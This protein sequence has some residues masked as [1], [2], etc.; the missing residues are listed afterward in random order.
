MALSWFLDIFCAAENLL[1]SMHLHELLALVIEVE[2]VLSC[3]PML[4]HTSTSPSATSMSVAASFSLR[5]NW[6]VAP[7]LH[8][9]F[10]SVTGGLLL[11]SCH[12]ASACNLNTTTYCL[13][14][15]VVR[16]HR[17]RSNF[18]VRSR[19]SLTLTKGVSTDL[20]VAVVVNCACSDSSLPIPAAPSVPPGRA[21]ISNPSM[22]LP[23]L[24]CR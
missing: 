19:C 13:V 9:T 5:C 17:A 11:A 1:I 23:S 16:L 7:F 22:A 21:Q 18:C 10:C 15:F 24:S 12:A 6:R 20:I 3:N 4:L 2:V 8:R 14:G